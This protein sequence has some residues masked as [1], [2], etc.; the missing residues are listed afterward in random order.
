MIR[1]FHIFDSFLLIIF[2]VIDFF[3]FSIFYERHL[4]YLYIGLYSMSNIFNYSLYNI[5]TYK[6]G[7]IFFFNILAEEYFSYNYY[8]NKMK[9]CYLWKKV[10]SGDCGLSLH[11]YHSFECFQNLQILA[12][13]TTIIL[14]YTHKQTNLHVFTKIICNS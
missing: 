4:L 14:S 6:N 8:F 2:Y 13:S 12:K 7:Y 9:I 1:I 5:H 3:G 10:C 11:M